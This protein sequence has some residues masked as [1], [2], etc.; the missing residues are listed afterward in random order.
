VINSLQSDTGVRRWHVISN[1]RYIQLRQ[2]R[3]VDAARDG[4]LLAVCATGPEYAVVLR[5]Y[6][7]M[8]LSRT[9]ADEGDTDSSG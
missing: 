1:I 3:S 4:D 8:K 2:R 5:D 7:L 9:G 6:L